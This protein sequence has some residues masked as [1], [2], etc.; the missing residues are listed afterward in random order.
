MF[1]KRQ[2]LFLLWATGAG[3]IISIFYL[4]V[5]LLLSIV[6]RSHTSSLEDQVVS[7]LSN[8]LAEGN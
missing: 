7:A 6:A 2:H 3:L 8:D 1:H 5:T 4:A